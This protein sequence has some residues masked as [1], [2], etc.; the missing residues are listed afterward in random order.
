MGASFRIWVNLWR[1][2]L[3]FFGPRPGCGVGVSLGTT[4]A[5]VEVAGMGVSVG[6]ITTG[7]LVFTGLGLLGGFGLLVGGIGLGLLGGFGLLVGR[8]GVGLFGGFRVAVGGI[9]V[10]L[11]G[12]FG[13]SVGGIG[14][15]VGTAG[16]STGWVVAGTVN[17]KGGVAVAS[18]G[19]GVF[20]AGTWVGAGLFGGMLFTGFSGR[21]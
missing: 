20:R 12:G 5:G 13:V 18:A 19:T 21:L 2:L 10:G 3:H 6:G 11:L 9:G 7:V 4:G 8:I 15:T 1:S 16:D 17:R 14:V